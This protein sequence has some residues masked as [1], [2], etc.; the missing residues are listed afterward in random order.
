VHERLSLM[1]RPPELYPGIVQLPIEVHL[2]ML[3]EDD[4]GA[5]VRVFSK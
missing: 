2:E 1:V 5:T 4:P 3:A